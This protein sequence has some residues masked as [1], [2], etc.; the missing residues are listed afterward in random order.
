M[1]SA[2]AMEPR[3]IAITSNREAEREERA[4]SSSS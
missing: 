2:V 4:E 1:L 3:E